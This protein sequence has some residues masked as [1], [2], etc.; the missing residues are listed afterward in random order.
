[1]DFVSTAGGG[2]ILY[3]SGQDLPVIKALEASAAL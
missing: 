3:M 2:L 1:V